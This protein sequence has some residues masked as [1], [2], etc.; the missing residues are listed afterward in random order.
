MD[1]RIGIIKKRLERVKRVIAV[2]GGKGGIGK[3]VVAAAL[4]L[5]L[6]EKGKKAGLFDA[7][8]CGPVFI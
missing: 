1:P 2:S 5:I 3:S 6:R 4:S 8:F 7:D